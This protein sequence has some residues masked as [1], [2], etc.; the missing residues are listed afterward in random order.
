LDQLV[1]LMQ[2]VELVDLFKALLD[3]QVLE[4]RLQV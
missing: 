3:Q 4:E 2:V 1:A